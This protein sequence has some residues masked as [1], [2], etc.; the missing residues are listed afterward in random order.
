M[1][2]YQKFEGKIMEFGTKLNNLKIKKHFLKVYR[3]YIYKR[4]KI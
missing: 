3:F 4:D 2:F 1:S